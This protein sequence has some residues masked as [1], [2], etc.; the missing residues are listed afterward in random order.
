MNPK[1]VYDLND[2]KEQLF[3]YT[4]SD[5]E[6]DFSIDSFQDFKDQME[7][8][9]ILKKLNQYNW[10]ISKTAEVIGIQRSHLY[11]KIKKYGLEKEDK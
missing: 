2:V 1:Q 10:N 9:F 7:K 5:S 3:P 11:N 6:I 8:I 4:K